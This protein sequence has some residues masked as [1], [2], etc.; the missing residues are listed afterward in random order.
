MHEWEFES[1]PD[2][3]MGKL[4]RVTAQHEEQRIFINKHFFYEQIHT[5]KYYITKLAEAG[6]IN[7]SDV[8]RKLNSTAIISFIISGLA[9]YILYTP[10][11]SAF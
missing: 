1:L 3:N 10:E 2:A 8:H 7:C 4:I 6:Q 9:N 5:R 11:G